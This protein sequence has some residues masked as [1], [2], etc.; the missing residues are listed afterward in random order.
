MPIQRRNPE[1]VGLLS[2]DLQPRLEPNF[3]WGQAS[4]ILLSSHLR[5]HWPMSS[6]D[7]NGDV[8]DLS[9]QGRTLTNNNA[10]TFNVKSICPYA[11]FQSASTQYLSRTDEAGLDLQSSM[12]CGAWVYFDNAASGTEYIMA[13]RA[14][15]AHRSFQ[16]ARLSTGVLRFG[17]CNDG[18]N[19]VNSD[20]TDVLA[21]TTW[22]FTWGRFVSGASRDAGINRD[23]WDNA[24]AVAAI[25]DSDA[26]FTIGASSTPDGYMD[27]RV[28]LPFLCA[29]A[30]TD[31]QIMN[32]FEQT[33]AMFGV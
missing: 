1:L 18:T 30:L 3:A 29:T 28:A 4:G 7:E 27:G 25:F 22:Y 8:Y 15:A 11:R 2:A 9:G 13:K 31:A 21:A 6:V 14:G 10:A 32:I 33:R 12:T 24:T 26:D 17:F 20:S 16:L 5:G 19:F 23:Y